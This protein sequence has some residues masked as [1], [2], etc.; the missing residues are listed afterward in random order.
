MGNLKP[1]IAIIFCCIK[2]KHPKY[3]SSHFYITIEILCV[4][5][6]L[7]G[8]AEADTTPLVE[9][10][11]R[12]VLPV[13]L[14]VSIY[15]DFVDMQADGGSDE[16]E[17]INRYNREHESSGYS[18]RYRGG[19]GYTHNYY[20]KYPYRY[21]TPYNRYSRGGYVSGSGYVPLV[22]ESPAQILY[23]KNLDEYQNK[24]ASASQKIK[25]YKLDDPYYDDNVDYKFQTAVIPPIIGDIGEW[26][27]NLMKKSKKRINEGV[28]EMKSGDYINGAKDITIGTGGAYI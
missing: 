17:Y 23:Q 1:T 24:A 18:P 4:I 26:F 9:A 15:Y 5:D 11:S 16:M 7:W 28:N 3:E 25:G 14:V 22:T 12:L 19:H 20:P 13:A 2:L 8:D 6:D 10:A 27:K 21:S